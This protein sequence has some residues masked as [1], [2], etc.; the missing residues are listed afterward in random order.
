MPQNI[1]GKP[2]TLGE[3]TICGK[4]KNRQDISIKSKIEKVNLT[5]IGGNFRE[6]YEY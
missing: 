2:I 5:I 4:I 3:K 6:E 1:A